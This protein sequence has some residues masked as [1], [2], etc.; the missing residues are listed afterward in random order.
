MTPELEK[1]KVVPAA[2]QVSLSALMETDERRK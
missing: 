2:Y 1:V